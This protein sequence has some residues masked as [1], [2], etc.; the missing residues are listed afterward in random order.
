MNLLRRRACWELVDGREGC[1]SIQ[2]VR[3]LLARERGP[4]GG[5]ELIRGGWFVELFG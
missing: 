5:L 2:L 3:G 4:G 1:Y